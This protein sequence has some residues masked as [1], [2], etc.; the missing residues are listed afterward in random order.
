MPELQGGCS[1][2]K[3]RYSLTLESTGDAK[4]SL[5][6]CHS[7]KQAYGGAFGVTARVT[8]QSFSVTKGEPKI[9]K[10]GNG[11]RREFCSECGAFVCEYGAQAEPYFRYVVVGSLDDGPDALPPTEELFTSQRSKWMPKI[12]DTFQKERIVE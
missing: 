8:R 10:H 7:C 11:V 12:P 5:C 9:Y 4:T 1:C 6:H 3:L 2:G